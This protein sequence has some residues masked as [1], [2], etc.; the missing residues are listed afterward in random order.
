MIRPRLPL[1]IIKVDV[2]GSSSSVCASPGGQQVAP[3]AG[4]QRTR[5]SRD[6]EN[7][8]TKLAEVAYMC[9]TRII[10][11][12]KNSHSKTGTVKQLVWDKEEVNISRDMRS[13][14][15][16][17]SDLAARSAGLSSQTRRASTP[18]D[19]ALRETF[20]FNR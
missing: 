3:E 7:S 18:Q 9:Y 16:A 13:T 4:T 20:P 5:V 1:T 14:A 11:N 8:P 19:A 6:Q 10:K 12:K 15:S 17:L 2:D